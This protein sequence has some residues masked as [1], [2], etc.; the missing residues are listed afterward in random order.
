MV[1]FTK[2]DCPI[3]KDRA[4]VS[5][6]LIVMI[7][8]SYAS[9]NTCSHTLIVAPLGCIHIEGSSLGF[10]LKIVQNGI[11]RPNLNSIPYAHI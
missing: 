5:P 10:S 11:Y 8:L 6:T 7:F 4:Y 1:R 9:R 3:L 2:L